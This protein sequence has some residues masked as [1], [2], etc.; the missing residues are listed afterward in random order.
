MISESTESYNGGDLVKRTLLVDVLASGPDAVSELVT[1]LNSASH[2]L[3][4]TRIEV[5]SEVLGYGTDQESWEGLLAIYG[6]PA[7]DELR[8]WAREDWKRKW[9]LK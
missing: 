5:E 1:W 2:D 3:E 8:A 4:V 6:K 7:T 9:G